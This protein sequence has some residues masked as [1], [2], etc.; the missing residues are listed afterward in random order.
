ML[1]WYFGVFYLSK[2]CRPIT[3]ASLPSVQVQTWPDLHRENHHQQDRGDLRPVGVC[4]E[5]Q[6]RLP[7]PVPG[8]QVSQCFLF[9][10]V[11][12]NREYPLVLLN[13]VQSGLA[14]NLG[15]SISSLYQPL[16]QPWDSPRLVWPYYLLLQAL[17]VQCNYC[18]RGSLKF[19][20]HSWPVRP[21][22]MLKCRADVIF[23]MEKLETDRRFEV[24]YVT[25][26][27]FIMR[28]WCHSTYL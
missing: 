18:H 27:V 6:V 2:F 15:P 3:S 22:S 23:G 16:I 4:R 1:S 19:F 20:L 28:S 25:T 11:I 13:T 9:V 14:S 7:G 8:Y 26:L 10:C 12:L 24:V 5:G 17:S 21:G